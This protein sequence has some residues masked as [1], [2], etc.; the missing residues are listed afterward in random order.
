MS[1][2]NTDTNRYY[3]DVAKHDKLASLIRENFEADTRKAFQDAYKGE[4]AIV[5]W[6]QQRP[7][8]IK[9]QYAIDAFIEEL[10]ETDGFEAMQVVLKESTCPHVAALKKTIED[11]YIK[12]WVDEIVEIRV[13]S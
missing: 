6:V 11:A 9:Y 2:V 8:Q 12:R 10:A 3:D 13:N 5:D 7:L 1:D 4:M